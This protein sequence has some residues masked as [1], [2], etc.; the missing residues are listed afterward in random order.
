MVCVIDVIVIVF[1]ECVGII[2]IDSFLICGFFVKFE[3]MLYWNGYGI[4]SYVLLFFLYGYWEYI[5]FGFFK[6]VFVCDLQLVSSQGGLGC[7]MVVR[8]RSLFVIFQRGNECVKRVFDKVDNVFFLYI[9]F[10]M[11]MYIII[12]LFQENVQDEFIYRLWLFQ[13]YVIIIYRFD[14]LGWVF[15]E[16]DRGFDWDEYVYLLVVLVG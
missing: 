13:W 6:K 7:N 1:V 3:V 15:D 8:L 2:Y 12:V 11:E 4:V 14:L 5:C 10:M 16:F 9:G